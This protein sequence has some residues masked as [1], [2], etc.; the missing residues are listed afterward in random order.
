MGSRGGKACAK[1]KH[2]SAWGLGAARR[3]PRPSMTRHSQD[4]ACARHARCPAG[5][6]RQQAAGSRQQAAGSRQQAAGSRQGRPRHALRHT[7]SSRPWGRPGG[8]PG[9]SRTTRAPSRTQAPP[10]GPPE[11]R[12][13]LAAPG[14]QRTEPIHRGEWGSVCGARVPPSR[15]T[16]AGPR[17]RPPE[18]GKR[19]VPFCCTL[20]PCSTH[21]RARKASRPSGWRP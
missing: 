5:D 4:Q 12:R 3:A 6:S 15:S 17:V 11:A 14:K 21:V 8:G 1:T 18:Q 16:G 9:W 10:V 13:T 2:D 19:A 7:G 20:V